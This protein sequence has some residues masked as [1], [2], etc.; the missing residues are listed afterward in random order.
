[1]GKVCAHARHRLSLRR[2]CGCV[3][4]STAHTEPGARRGR[5]T[6]ACGCRTWT[7]STGGSTTP[8]SWRRRR[9]CGVGGRASRAQRPSHT[10]SVVHLL[11]LWPPWL[12]SGAGVRGGGQGAAGRGGREA[13]HGGRQDRAGQGHA[14]VG[15]RWRWC[16]WCCCAVGA[17]FS[18]AASPPCKRM[19]RATGPPAP[20]QQERTHTHAAPGTRCTLQ[21]CPAPAASGC[22]GVGADLERGEGEEEPSGATAPRREDGTGAVHEASSY[23]LRVLVLRSSG[24]CCCAC[25]LFH[26]S[27]AGWSGPSARARARPTAT[28]GSTPAVWRSR[29]RRCR[30]SSRCDPSAEQAALTSSS[31]QHPRPASTQEC[32]SHCRL[33]GPGCTGAGS[34]RLD[35]RAPPGTAAC[36]R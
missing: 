31:D 25:A 35:T 36:R 30:S 22:S 27:A 29:R 23:A 17:A 9:R 24:A 28:T 33:C 19:R 11:L 26:R 16:C 14:A 34:L 8:S 5:A 6:R 15:A 1:M 2:P 13:G 12:S 3:G 7:A 4:W 10:H 32:Q 21:Y 18:R 20:Q